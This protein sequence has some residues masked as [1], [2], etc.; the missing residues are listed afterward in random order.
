[1]PEGSL[2][3]CCL[4]NLCAVGR[5][6][7]WL[8][9]LGWQWHV[10]EAVRGETLYLRTYGAEG[11]PVNQ[12]VDLQPDL[13]EGVLVECAL[14]PGEETA[15]YVQLAGSLGDGEAL[16]L[17]LA[18]TRHWLLATDDRKARRL[19]GELGVPVITTPELARRWADNTGSTDVE[20]AAALCRVRDLA[21]FVPGEGFPLRDW[22]VRH[23]E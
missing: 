18:A 11:E 21:R 13:A 14:D 6:A 10:P 3:T 1:M 16:A 4:L 2:D 8:P 12:E 7:D 15:R 5:V 19:A 22:R 17:A 23:L 9:S 20:I